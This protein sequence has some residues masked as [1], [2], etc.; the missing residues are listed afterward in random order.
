MYKKV[1]FFLLT[2]FIVVLYIRFLLFLKISPR[3]DPDSN[4]YIEHIINIYDGR[5]FSIKDYTDEQIKPTAYRMPLFQYLSYIITKL[6]FNSKEDILNSIEIINLL[7]SIVLLINSFIIS[8]HLTSN[9]YIGFLT[10]LLTLL[11]LN[12]L[13]NSTLIMTDT[14]HAAIASIS[15]T[16]FI[17]A[18][19]NKSLIMFLI[20]GM[21]LRLAVLTRPILKFYP[22]ILTVVIYLN[23]IKER[24]RFKYTIIPLIGFILVITP[25][26]VR[27]Y[28]KMNFL[29]LETNQGLNTLWSTSS[30]VE[31]K[32]KD[33][34][35]PIIYEIKKIIIENRQE[36]PWPMGAEVKARKKLNLSEVES[37]KYFQRIGIE[38]I[39]SN[40][41][42]FIKIFL[43][44]LLNNITSAT[45]ELKM[46]DILFYNGYYELQH[47]IM[48]RFEN[49]EKSDK[50]DISFKES[51]LILPN[52]IF[53][54]IHL[55]S[56]IIAMIGGYFYI[57]ENK[58]IGIFLLSFIWYTL[59]LTSFVG[60]YDRYRMP[61]EIIL[62]FFISIIIFKLYLNKLKFNFSL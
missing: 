19:K 37:A 16:F 33:L 42:G 15:I 12:I 27:N 25:W 22:I 53:R 40:P 60:S 11:N 52:F 30:L 10:L 44:N 61:F 43:R 18:M 49:I 45:S 58:K 9:L 1:V 20:G 6:I 3:F 5:G 36:S 34:K 38:T 29:G 54:I 51:L 26:I 8:Y 24:G 46:I 59:L 21:A 47:N 23:F 2:F 7:S 28:K 32:E 14:L 4:T 55:I 41:V 56:F 31:I 62:N 57:K 50:K 17:F 35:E 13:Y 48:I 39:L